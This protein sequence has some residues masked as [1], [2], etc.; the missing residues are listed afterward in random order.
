MKYTSEMDTEG[1]PPKP[2][3]NGLEFPQAKQMPG[4]PQL[5]SATAVAAPGVADS[6]VARGK[7]LV[8]DNGCTA[9]HS[10]GTDQLVG[11]GWGGLY[12]TTVKLVDGT[13]TTADDAYLTEK[14][15]H[16]DARI[17]AGFEAG[18]MPSYAEMLDTEEVSDI[19]AFLKSL[20]G[21]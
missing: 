8:A 12:G 7:E 19:V 14:I 20:G 3:V 10:V 17:V 4:A 15:L 13:T 21:K 16:P 18:V 11:P 6:P 1:W 9:C 2:K 5:A